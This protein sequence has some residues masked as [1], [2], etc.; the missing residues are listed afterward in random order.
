MTQKELARKVNVHWSYISK[1]ENN[2]KIPSVKVIIR[3]SKILG[4]DVCELINE[5]GSES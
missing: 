2:K 4:I 3:I 5:N 1:I